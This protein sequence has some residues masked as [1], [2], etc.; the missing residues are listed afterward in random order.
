MGNNAL[1]VFDNLVLA[2]SD[3]LPSL[4]LTNCMI[5]SRLFPSMNFQLSSHL[6]LGFIHYMVLFCLIKIRDMDISFLHFLA[7]SLC[8]FPNHALIITFANVFGGRN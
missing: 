3:F 7:L 1:F 2:P 5:L 4:L 6:F 8:A